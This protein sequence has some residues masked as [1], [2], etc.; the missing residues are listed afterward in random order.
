MNE[1]FK[2][3]LGIS[4]LNNNTNKDP[5]NDGPENDTFI[6]AVVPSR[7]YGV[8]SDTHGVVAQCLRQQHRRLSSPYS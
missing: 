6:R 5:S 3:S 4:L 8:K 2:K 1:A 7:C